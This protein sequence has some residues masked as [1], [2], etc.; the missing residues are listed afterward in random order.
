MSAEVTLDC[1][2]GQ[3]VQQASAVLAMSQDSDG[4]HEGYIGG[5]GEDKGLAGK[6]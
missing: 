4:E 6:I 5:L 2:C 1:V 3:G